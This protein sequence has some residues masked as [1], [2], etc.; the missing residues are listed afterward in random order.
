MT[1]VICIHMQTERKKERRREKTFHFKSWS[2]CQT[3]PFSLFIYDFANERR[4][5]NKNTKWRDYSTRFHLSHIHTVTD[6]ETPRNMM[7]EI[8]CMHFTQQENTF[9]IFMLRSQSG[10]HF[11]NLTLPRNLTLH[12]LIDN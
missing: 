1:S 4:R 10:K 7:L 2:Q 9:I 3:L 8:F 11:T 6:K 12:I 5:R